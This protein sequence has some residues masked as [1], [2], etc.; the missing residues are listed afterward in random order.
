MDG[1]SATTRF[2]LTFRLR[3]PRTTKYDLTTRIHDVEEAI[4]HHN[5]ENRQI[6]IT[7]FRVSEKK[8]NLEV[9][10]P[11][12]PLTVSGRSFV[13]FSR[14]LFHDCRW[15]E[16]FSAAPKSL[17]YLEKSE[18]LLHAPVSITD[19]SISDIKTTDDVTYEPAN[20]SDSDAI[21]IFETLC[22]T[23][24]IGHNIQQKHAVI[25]KIKEVLIEWL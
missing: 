1:D 11:H 16:Y 22:L 25:N 17:F 10:Y 21:K 3:A 6:K 5:S 4:V 15:G 18:P 8:I 24:N 14:Y 19:R 13:G 12:P 2:Q 9:E 7:A 23:K 20:I